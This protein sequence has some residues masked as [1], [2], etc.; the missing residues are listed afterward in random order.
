MAL[1]AVKHFRLCEVT[2]LSSSAVRTKTL[3]ARQTFNKIP[4][5]LESSPNEALKRVNPFVPRK[6][7]KSGCWAPP[8]YS[9]RRQADLVKHARASNTVHMLPPGPKLSAAQIAAALAKVTAN[10]R[11]NGARGGGPGPGKKAWR[12]PVQWEG[13]VKERNVAGADV[14]NR[15]YAGKKRMFKGHKWERTRDKR[16]RR[17]KIMVRDMDKRIARYKTHY[18]RRRP[19]PLKPPVAQKK[20]PKLPF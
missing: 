8:K 4:N 13:K 15:L 19:K 7:P 14:G 17:T 2:S 11:T 5:E 16:A 9:L 12:L 20:A 10:P 1:R 3:T 18:A 6:N